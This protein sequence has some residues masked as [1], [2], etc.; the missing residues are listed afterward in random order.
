M[1]PRS[2]E[3]QHLVQECQLQLIKCIHGDKGCDVMIL[4]KDMQ[5]HLKE[6]IFDKIKIVFQRIEVL[7]KQVKM[8][9]EKLGDQVFWR[10]K[11]VD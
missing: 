1:I 5:I 4:R 2:N 8:Q 7:E 9:N 3:S 11:C 10:E 6:C